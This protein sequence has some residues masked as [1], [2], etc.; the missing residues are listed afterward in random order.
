MSL[1]AVEDAV[2]AIL[3]GQVSALADPAE[4]WVRPPTFLFLTT[5]QI[6][7]WGGSFAESRH[8]MPRLY[9]QKRVEHKLI[10]WLQLATSS[11]GSGPGSA[12]AFPLLIDAVTKTLRSIPIPIPLVDTTTGETSVMQS[13]GQNIDTKHPVPMAAAPQSTILWQNA[14]LTVSITEEIVG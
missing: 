6:F 10:I 7:V 14:T 3:S 4:A 2:Q 1:V 12:L 8:T 11:D 5:P 13:I 9:G